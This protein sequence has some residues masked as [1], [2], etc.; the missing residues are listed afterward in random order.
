MTGEME[1][2]EINFILP[3]HMDAV[4]LFINYCDPIEEAKN[5]FVST[6][7]YVNSLTKILKS[8]G[9]K[10]EYIN[11]FSSLDKGELFDKFVFVEV[12]RTMFD[13]EVADS[14]SREYCCFKVLCTLE[15]N[16]FIRY[17]NEYLLRQETQTN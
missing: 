15:V 3:V 11:H 8:A 9:I 14:C 6:D 1:I 13:H 2:Q 16:H 5:V 7:D 10:E 4:E 17:C 12:M